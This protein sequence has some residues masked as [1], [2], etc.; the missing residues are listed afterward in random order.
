MYEN[1]DDAYTEPDVSWV[2]LSVLGT[3]KRFR[4]IHPWHHK[5]NMYT[6][7]ITKLLLQTFANVYFIIRQGLH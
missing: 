1:L 6:R 3:L 7:K 4:E 2:T 5:F